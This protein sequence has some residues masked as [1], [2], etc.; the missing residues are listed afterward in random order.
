MARNSDLVTLSKRYQNACELFKRHFHRFISVWEVYR[1]THFAAFRSLSFLKK[2]RRTVFERVPQHYRKTKFRPIRRYS[3]E[4][5]I[6]KFRSKIL[7][8]DR[9][10]DP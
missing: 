7:P 8:K 10:N 4:N 2:A 3:P 5:Q 1:E 9:S 6:T